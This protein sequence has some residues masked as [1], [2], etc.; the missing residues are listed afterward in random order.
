MRAKRVLGEEW[1]LPEELIVIWI[2]GFEGYALMDVIR[3]ARDNSLGA[4]EL[5]PIYFASY[6]RFKVD[7]LLG[8]IQRAAA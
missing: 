8:L 3:S 2:R 5:A 6:D 7:Q 4:T 1:G